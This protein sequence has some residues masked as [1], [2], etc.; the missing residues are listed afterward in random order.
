MN[1]KQFDYNEIV[2]AGEYDIPG[3]EITGTVLDIG[4]NLGAFA[5][6]ALKRWPQC[7]VIAYEP[8][9]WSFKEL[10]RKLG[11]LSR[12][13]CVNAAVTKIQNKP[14]RALIYP[15]IPNTSTSSMHDDGQQ[16]SVSIEVPAISP[17]DLPPADF[18]KVDTE[19]C[20]LEII[21]TYVAS[22]APLGIALEYHSDADREQIEPFLSARGYD[23]R[24]HQT[25]PELGLIYATRV[26]LPDFSGIRI[27]LGVIHYGPQIYA[28]FEQS[29]AQCER[30]GLL[31]TITYQSDSLVSRCRNTVTKIFL[32]GPASH[33]LFIDTDIIFL[34]E[35]VRAL[36]DA[37][38][39]GAEVIGGLYPLKGR[40]PFWCANF[41][42]GEKPDSKGW[43]K[44]SKLGTGFLLVARSVFDRIAAAN[45]ANNY[46]SDANEGLTVSSGGQRTMH[47]WWEVGVW[48]DRPDLPGRYLSEDWFFC[49]R[50]EQLGIPVYAHTGI[51]LKH[52]GTFAYPYDRW[53]DI[54]GA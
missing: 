33:L 15:G 32:D 47:D 18:V 42:Q 43:L 21:L 38:A 16:D 26:R 2:E 31:H 8:M 19:G 29:R 48:R 41:I 27:H 24:V 5:G 9:P 53:P 30:H 28:A 54:P 11:A 25:G 50:C 36:R 10:R 51:R 22:H 6:W 49:K 35:H 39:A 46:L 12:V 4:A 20:E 40:E 13:E 23:L 52:Q 37:A 14:G 7:N 34:P 3:L 1:A 45:P 44:V 17:R